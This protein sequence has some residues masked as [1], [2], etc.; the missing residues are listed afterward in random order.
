MKISI[1][2]PTYQRPF[3]LTRCVNS[4][5]KQDFPSSDYEII[6]VSDGP[7]AQTDIAVTELRKEA[8]A[9]IHFYSL[10]LKRGPAAARNFGWKKAKA[11]LVTFTDDDCIPDPGWLSAMW[12][13]FLER[14]SSRVAFSGRTLVPLPPEPTDYERNIA[15]LETAEFITAN[16]A[17]TKEALELAGGFDEA[18]T[19]AWREDSDLQFKLDIHGVPIVKVEDAR[20]T[21]PVRKAAWGVSIKEERKGMFNALLYKKFPLLYK[22]RIQP[23]PPWHYYIIVSFLVFFLVGMISGSKA[24]TSV[25]IAGWCVLTLWFTLK[26]LKNTSHS[27]NHVLEM[28]ATSAVIPVLSIYWRIYGSWKFKTLLFP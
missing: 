25:S 2:I 11:Q 27:L 8:A 18:F 28:V 17:C 19:L 24:M 23:S 1:V 14:S 13:A 3:L 9:A 12:N 16:C 4:L 10:S 26:R 21:H 20:I 15:N 6:I 5:L 7:D 22:Q